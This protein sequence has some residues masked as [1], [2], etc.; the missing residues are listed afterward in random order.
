MSR[1]HKARTATSQPARAR[2]PNGRGKASDRGTRA[3][4]RNKPAS[5]A[6][7]IATRELPFDFL[8]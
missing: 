8:S 7:E 5:F 1:V 2:L 4:E 6:L 3:T